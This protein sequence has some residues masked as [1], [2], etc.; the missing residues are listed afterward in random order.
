M[1]HPTI[2]QPKAIR[3]IFTGTNKSDLSHYDG[4]S[5][6]MNREGKEI[7]ARLDTRMFEDRP[8][9]TFPETGSWKNVKPD[10][11]TDEEIQAFDFDPQSKV[12]RSR[13]SL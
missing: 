12:I 8:C 3:G 7:I 13:L 5:V 4:T 6:L 1:A 11:L 2:Q 9:L 10:M